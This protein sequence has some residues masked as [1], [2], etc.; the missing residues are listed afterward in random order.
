M[1]SVSSIRRPL[2]WLISSSIVAIF[3]ML[4]KSRTRAA[5]TTSFIWSTSVV[6]EERMCP[7]RVRWKYP[8]SSRRRWLKSARAEVAHQP[9]LDRHEE[10]RRE[11]GHHVAQQ[12]PEDEDA[13]EARHRR[14]WSARR[15]SADRAATW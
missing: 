2:I 4:W 8:R 9:F 15:G 10:L 11:V 1:V 3:T 5:V 12:Q 14:R 7:W 13:E 6:I